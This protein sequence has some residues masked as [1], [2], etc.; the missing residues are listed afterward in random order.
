MINNLHK[1][2][3]L[4]DFDDNSGKFLYVQLVRRNKDLGQGHQRVIADF[5]IRSKADLLM[6][7]PHII[8]LSE[9]FQARAY[10]DLC[11]RTLTHTSGV[12]LKKLAN[13]IVDGN[14]GFLHPLL[15]S[16]IATSKPDRKLFLI[17]LDKDPRSLSAIEDLEDEVIRCLDI[18]LLGMAI[19]NS[20]EDRD[21]LLGRFQTPNGIHL[22]TKPFDKRI[23]SEHFQNIDIKTDCMGTILYYPKSLGDNMGTFLWWENFSD[24]LGL[25]ITVSVDEEMKYSYKITNH[26]SSVVNIDP[27]K[28]TGSK[29]GTQ[30]EAAEAAI[31]VILDELYK[32]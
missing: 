10:V 5:M 32:R 8:L 17:D 19:I 6:K 27:L 26:L 4:I 3:R 15:A 29:F 28:A 11:T 18:N 7:M 20:D 31:E 16:A 2:L 23:L 24:F 21:Y 25:D 22:I 14:C 9:F 12:L 1:V 13:N 30:T